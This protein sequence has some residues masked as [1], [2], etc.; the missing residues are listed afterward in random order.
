MSKRNWVV[1]VVTAALTS[2][3]VGL[4]A[5]AAMTG[6]LLAGG[7]SK[8]PDSTSRAMP[9]ITATEIKIGQTLPYS[10]PASGFS[11]LGKTDRAY[12]TMVNDKGG[13]N[14]RKI[15]LI[16]L[17]DS[18]SPPKAREQ[19]RKLVE[20]EGVAFMFGSVGTAPNTAVQGYLNDNKV[21]QL[22][23]VSGADK[24]ADP[25][26]FPWTMGWQPSFR[27]EAHIYARYLLKEKPAAKICVLYQND[28]LGKDY[29]AGLREVFGGQYDQLVVKTASYEV[30]DP[31]VD[32][33][34]VTLQAAGCDT[35]ITAAIPRFA[36]QAIRKVFD[37]GWNPLHIMS[38]VAVSITTGQT[39]AELEKATGIIT[40]IFLK[41]PSDPR[42]AND[43][44]MTDYRAFMKQYLPDVDPTD[45]N[46][47]FAYGMSMTLASVLAKCGNDLSRENIMKQAASLTGFVVP[48]ATPGTEVTTSA[49][50]YRVFSQLQLA[51]FNGTIFEPFGD[52]Q[53]GD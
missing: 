9:G 39:P 11:T 53:S 43:P 10:G 23:I 5:L 34:V 36:A 37:I 25:A 16:S 19:T 31:T 45:A 1:V 32:S 17:D 2:S 24:F 48:V 49:T 42:L 13:I 27:I 22:F 6:V 40:G 21:P 35:L 33:Q 41:N 4:L 8:K 44:G 14:G 28:D 20:G 38:N 46:A 47:I 51:R 7:C 50:D 29:L 30:T 3:Y 15:N 52:V 12:F 18:Y 26:H